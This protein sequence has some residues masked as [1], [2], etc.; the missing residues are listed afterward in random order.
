MGTLDAVASAT[1]YPGYTAVV[2][3][4]ST[5]LSCARFLSRR[6][7]PF[8]ITDSRQMPP[9][10]A[11]GR[12]LA[13]DAHMYLG[14]IDDR[15]LLGASQ[16]VVSP[17]VSLEEPAIAAA[18]RAGVPVIGDIELF[19][20]ELG[21]AAAIVA[22]TGSN[23]KSSVTTLLGAMAQ[24]AGRRVVVGGNLGTPALDVLPGDDTAPAPELYVLEL[25]S[26]QLET[27]ASL[28]PAA[29]V[30]L[31]LSPDHMD[32]H[33]SLEAYAAAKARVYRGKGV[34]VLNRDDPRVMAM[35]RLG[36]RH[37]DFG[38][39]APGPTGYGLVQSG[40]SMWLARGARLLTRVDELLLRGRHN[41]AN[42]L[43]AL[44]LAEAIALPLEPCLQALRGFA[45]LPHRC[46]LVTQRRGV[47]WYNDSKG[48]NVGA[49]AAA[50]AG[51]VPPGESA[52]MVLLAGGVGKGAD[53]RPLAEVL[54]DRARA[55]V[56]IGRDA[57]LIEAAVS[58]VA[59]VARARDLP[60]AVTVAAALA[61]PGDVVLLS[62]A[63]ASFD[64]FSGYEARGEAFVAAVRGLGA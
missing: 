8:R 25:S 23:G 36:R 34:M 30:V 17:G 35:L 57:A 14:R 18:T 11:E 22:I 20:R 47:A 60:Q 50:I 41:W 64:M 37:I 40:E 24:A 46:E 55:V 3:L 63:C 29:A 51:L 19:A 4:G 13:G 26:F 59:R 7:V 33:H 45:G 27:T 9:G 49:T 28:A 56:L 52:R 2:G 38:L 53:F 16:V 44:A 62:P 42:A 31:N 6:G 43:A 58:H 10:L 32:R 5:G 1:T 15:L 39:G 12:A 61:R 21:A 54:R 48:T